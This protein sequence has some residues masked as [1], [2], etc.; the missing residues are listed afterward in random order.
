MRFLLI[1]LGGIGQRHTRNLRALFGPDCELLA[2]R[3]RRASPVLTDALQVDADGRG[4]EERYGIRAFDTLEAALEA[5]PDAALIC[6]PTS[7]HMQAALAAARA[8][9]HLLLEKP[10]SNSLDHSDELAAIVAKNGLVT[11]VA[12]QL[13]FHP[14]LKLAHRLLREGAIGR[15][16]ACRAVIGEYLPGWHP[17]ED[18]RAMYASQSALGGGVVLS[19]IHEID[20]LYWFFGRPRRVVAMGGHWSDLEIDVEDVASTL[21]EYDRMVAH[22]HQDYVQQPPMRQFEIIASAGKILVDLR[23]A[24]IAAFGKEGR[25]ILTESFAPLERNSLFLDELKCFVNAVQTGTSVPANLHDGLQS[26][27]MALAVRQSLESRRSVDMSHRRS[28]I[29]HRSLPMSYRE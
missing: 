17:Y 15:P 10:L 14:C 27:E 6:N 28:D 3:V 7:L 16:L 20:L 8:G 11:M 5:R 9:C 13:R 21:F 24:S 23:N 2:Y 19:Q 22:L 1:G 12:Y 29:A 18:Y 26:L 25:P 4:L